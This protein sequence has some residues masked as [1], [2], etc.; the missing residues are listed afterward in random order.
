M[1]Y[2]RRFNESNNNRFYNEIDSGRYFN[3]FAYGLSV[4][5]S[6][7]AQD[8]INKHRIEGKIDGLQEW[9]NRDDAISHNHGKSYRRIAFS[10]YPH[11]GWIKELRDEWF[12]VNLY[13]KNESAYLYYLCDQLDGLDNF[14]TDFS[15]NFY[16][17]PLYI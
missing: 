10:I 12:I 9:E 8:I 15:N 13:K 5:L 3:E 7:K 4:N 11:I 6:D 14:L 17:Y 16:H 1:K 2:L